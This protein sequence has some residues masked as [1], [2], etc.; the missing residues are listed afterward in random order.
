MRFVLVIGVLL[1][2]GAAACSGDMRSSEQAM[3]E[4]VLAEIPQFPGAIEIS[5][6]AGAYLRVDEFDPP[7][8]F[9]LRVRYTLPDETASTDVVD[10]YEKGSFLGWGNYGRQIVD[11]CDPPGGDW[12]LCGV[13]HIRFWRGD[14]SVVLVTDELIGGGR[15][16]ELIITPQECAAGSVEYCDR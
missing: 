12:D 8:G 11:D 14:T 16:Y 4:T 13:R 3:N 1:I 15:S 5:R 10:F 7:V 9:G 2:Y 6:Q